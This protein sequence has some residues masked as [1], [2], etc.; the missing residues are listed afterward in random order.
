M[1]ISIRYYT[2]SGHTQKLAEAIA[3]RI[4]V[5][6]ENISVPLAEKTDLLFL[7]CSYYAFDMAQDVKDFIA[8]NKDNIGKIVCFGTSAM[9]KSMKKPMR[10]L[11]ETC[12]IKLSDE[13]FHCRGEFKFVNKGKPDADDLENAALFAEG[14]VKQRR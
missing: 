1:N 8:A 7:G 5:K 6:A 4:H 12:G 10:K 2:R 3:E 13:E 14:I 9:M 11:T